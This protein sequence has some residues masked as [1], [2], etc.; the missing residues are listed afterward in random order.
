MDFITDYKMCDACLAVIARVAEMFQ[1]DV[2]GDTDDPEAPLMYTSDNYLLCGATACKAI[3]DGTRPSSGDRVMT[4]YGL[5]EVIEWVHGL[6]E[7]E[8][9]LVDHPPCL[10]FTDIVYQPP[11]NINPIKG[12]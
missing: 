3:T 11:R 10:E 8:L 1:D 5:A 4:K 9:R 6:G 7:Y 12:E 2:L